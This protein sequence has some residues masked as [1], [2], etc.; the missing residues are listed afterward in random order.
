MRARQQIVSG[1]RSGERITVVAADPGIHQATPFRWKR[2]LLNRCQASS[3][4]SLAGV[5]SY[6]TSQWS[7]AFGAFQLPDSSHS[8]KFDR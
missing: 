3:G 5:G 4:A 2:Q 1:P 7:S 8:T 6:M